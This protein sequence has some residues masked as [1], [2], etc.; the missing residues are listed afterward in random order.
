MYCRNILT[1]CI[2]ASCGNFTAQKLQWLQTGILNLVHHRYNPPLHE[3]H[4]K[5]T[6]IV[7]DSQHWAMSSSQRYQKAR[8]SKAQ[9]C[10]P[11]HHVQEQ[12]LSYSYRVLERTRTTLQ[13]PQQQSTT[14]YLTRY[15]GRGFSDYV[16]HSSPH[17]HL[18]SFYKWCDLCTICL[19]LPMCLW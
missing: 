16:V 9:R 4:F 3:K 1:S 13:Q 7:K 18:L 6:S 8:G 15:N 12:L 19:C 11:V 14:E 17:P 5:I 2:L 10:T